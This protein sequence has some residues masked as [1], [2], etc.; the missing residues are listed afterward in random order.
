MT[1]TLIETKTLGAAAASIELTSIPHTFTDLLVLFSSRSNRSAAVERAGL[2]FNNNFSNI[3][4]YRALV[5]TGSSTFSETDASDRIVFY[6]V[7]GNTATSN[8]FGSTSIYIPNYSASVNKSV[9]IDGVF[10]NNATE[11]W[12]NI[13]SGLFDTTTAITSLKIVPEIGTEFLTGTSISIY[14]VTKGTDGIVTTS[15]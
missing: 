9:S 12:Q 13:I 5:G 8:T 6:S 3:Y 14:G 1:M 11:A 7:S 15:P 4:T 2:R 10:E